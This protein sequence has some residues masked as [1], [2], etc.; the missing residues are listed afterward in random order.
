MTYLERLLP[1]HAYIRKI[2][3][4]IKSKMKQQSISILRGEFL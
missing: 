4:I 3:K 2:K 1:N